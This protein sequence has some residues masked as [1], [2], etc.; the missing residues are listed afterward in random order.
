MV[1]VHHQPMCQV[2]QPTV[3][4]GATC[5][6]TPGTDT[7]YFSIG[8]ERNRLRS[9]AHLAAT[10]GAT[11]LSTIAGMGHALSNAVIQQ[12]AETILDFTGEVDKAEPA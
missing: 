1:T 4:I 8:P 3:G 5:P 7:A 6:P 11:R 12:L 9:V 10:L 2:I